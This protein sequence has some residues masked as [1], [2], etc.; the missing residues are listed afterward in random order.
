MEKVPTSAFSVLKVESKTF[1]YIIIIFLSV[2]A[3]F[4]KRNI[5]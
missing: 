1:N 4:S 3:M 2:K 5:C